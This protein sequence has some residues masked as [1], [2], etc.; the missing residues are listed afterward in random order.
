[1]RYSSPDS[2]S[3]NTAGSCGGSRLARTKR[4]MRSSS[5][6]REM[7]AGTGPSSVGGSSVA[8]A[9]WPCSR[10]PVT[11]AS[12]SAA[13]AC[14]CFNLSVIAVS[15]TPTG[16]KEDATA[17]P[18]PPAN[19][20]TLLLE[21]PNQMGPNSGHGAAAKGRPARIKYHFGPLSPRASSS[22]RAWTRSGIQTTISA[23]KSL[24][25][26]A[27]ICRSCIATTPMPSSMHCLTKARHCGGSAATAK[28]S[29]PR[30]VS[31]FKQ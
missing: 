8:T 30:T 22:D 19:K 13:A 6:V 11:W 9:I 14:A 25:A 12:S 3:T 20:T 21:W 29:H 4:S 18:V 7:V 17:S 27:T 1:M 24:I 15:S 2:G 26:V 28:T 23:P 16:T 10:P 5:H 31:G